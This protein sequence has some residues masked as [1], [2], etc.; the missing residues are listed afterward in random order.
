MSVHLT[1]D[2]K[3]RRKGYGMSVK[4]EL[5]LIKASEGIP[6]IWSQAF[7]ENKPAISSHL[8]LGYKLVREKEEPLYF[9][10]FKSLSQYRKDD[11]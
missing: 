6:E 1:I 10:F 7:K 8:S 3:Y 11:L 2:Y 9:T 5:E 4:R